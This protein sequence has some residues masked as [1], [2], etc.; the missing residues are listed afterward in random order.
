MMKQPFIF[1]GL[2]QLI[3]MTFGCLSRFTFF[4]YKPSSDHDLNVRIR[5]KECHLLIAEGQIIG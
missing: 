4:L 5:N 3:F 2:L 1:N